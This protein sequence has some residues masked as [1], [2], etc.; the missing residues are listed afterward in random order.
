MKDAERASKT[1]DKIAQH[2]DK[3]RNRPWD[4]VVEFL[5]EIEGRVIDL[6]CGN[7]RHSLAAKNLGLDFVCLDASIKLLKIARKK[8][9]NEGIYV[10]SGLKK[11]PFKDDSFDNSIYIAAVHHL[12][13][14]RVKSLEESKRILKSGGKIL[15]SSWAREQDRWDLEGNESDINVP[16]NKPDGT[17][18]DRYYHLYRLDELANDVEKSGLKVLRKFRSKGNNYVIAQKN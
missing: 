1:F 14:N 12:S 2:F 18:V 13:N 5:K 15:I 17:V 16:W 10:R 6:G 4:E 11:L 9:E 3:T 7:G 8:T